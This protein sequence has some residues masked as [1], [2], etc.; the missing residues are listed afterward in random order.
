[1]LGFL[2]RQ[3]HSS[4]SNARGFGSDAGSG[5]SSPAHPAFLADNL[6]TAQ[7]PSKPP[8]PPPH[9]PHHSLQPPP[10]PRPLSPKEEPPRR[11]RLHLRPGAARPFARTGAN[12]LLFRVLAGAVRC[13]FSDGMT[14]LR[15]VNARFGDTFVVRSFNLFG[16]HVVVVKRVQLYPLPL[17]SVF[18]LR[19]RNQ[20]QRNDC[21]RQLSVISSR[22]YDKPLE[23][24]RMTQ[25]LAGFKYSVFICLYYWEFVHTMPYGY[26]NIVLES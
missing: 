14:P 3:L 17:V 4:S 16:M 18:G 6:A 2:Q 15:H 7:P 21:L 1:M 22:T 10:L 5:G 12:V 24:I 11:G 9:P 8:H 19:S 25:F 20:R 23:A 13:E 26:M